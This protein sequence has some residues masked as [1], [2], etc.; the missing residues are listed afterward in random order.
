MCQ[1]RILF[2][3]PRAPPPRENGEHASARQLSC[4]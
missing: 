2:R 4:L 1:P 3:G